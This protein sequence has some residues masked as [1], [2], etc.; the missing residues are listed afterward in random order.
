MARK[1][2]SI[3]RP[4]AV[5]VVD[6]VA[7]LPGNPRWHLGAVVGYLVTLVGALWVIRLLCT[8]NSL[9]GLDPT[10]AHL[11]EGVNISSPN[12]DQLN[13]AMES[14]ERAAIT[15]PRSFVKSKL[16]L[17]SVLAVDAWLVTN[18]AP[19]DI[20]AYALSEVQRIVFT[21]LPWN[22]LLNDKAL[23]AQIMPTILVAWSSRREV[24][25]GCCWSE[26]CIYNQVKTV[27][28]LEEVGLRN[29][30]SSHLRAVE[31][32]A[33]S[34]AGFN[35]RGTVW[36]L[37]RL[38]APLDEHYPV[39]YFG[40]VDASREPAFW[41]P[42]DLPMAAFLEYHAEEIIAELAPLCLQ[43]ADLSHSMLN[44]FGL[45]RVVEDLARNRESWLSLPLYDQGA[46]NV[47][48]CGSVAT[49]TCQLLRNRPELT[50]SLHSSAESGT[51]VQLP[52][53]S[54]YKLLPGSHIHRHVGSPWRLNAHLGLITPPGAELRV[55]N[56]SRV[57]EAGK[58]FA[59][60]DAAEHEVIHR[61][62]EARCVLNV[63]QWHPTVLE[64][65]HQDAAFSGR[66][67][68]MLSVPSDAESAV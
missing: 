56:E 51:V 52:F 68:G 13:Q 9:N 44:H 8:A 6:T 24:A 16:W 65:A 28:M 14:S 49:R 34:G 27:M 46:W 29:N 60:M 3:D 31:A 37:D 50:G 20:R 7:S 58:A 42:S 36:L 55:W 35:C 38:A 17:Q 30:A 43:A 63:V 39:E 57:W 18:G 59:F 47:S 11:V 26:T 2:R 41:G 53:V 12:L 21:F 61:G 5:A 23:V 45:E 1:R 22:D 32:I 33:G 40:L 15:G 48:A 25:E 67:D 19:D 62:L 66:F 64:R 54:V 10:V 4:A